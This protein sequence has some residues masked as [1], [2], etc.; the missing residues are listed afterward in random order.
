[1]EQEQEEEEV[2]MHRDRQ[3]AT[4]DNRK[5]EKTCDDDTLKS[6][7]NLIDDQNSWK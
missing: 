5:G 2:T 6:D 3:G 1:M 7:S 4:G